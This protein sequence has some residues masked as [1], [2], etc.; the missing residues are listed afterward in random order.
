[1]S[2]HSPFCWALS[3]VTGASPRTKGLDSDRLA[4]VVLLIG[5]LA[6]C[7]ILGYGLIGRQSAG[8]PIRISLTVT[9][10]GSS[11]GTTLNAQTIPN[12]STL[13]NSQ[14]LQTVSNA[15]LAPDATSQALSLNL[16]AG[17][18]T[19]SLDS[20]ETLDLLLAN[21]NLWYQYQLYKAISI[22]PS[23]VCNLTTA[24]ADPSAATG[25]ILFQIP[26]SGI[27]YLAFI[28]D[29]YTNPTTAMY[30]VQISILATTAASSSSTG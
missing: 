14:N 15:L 21:A 30:S 12:Q 2:L 18:L 8:S 16:P 1:M 29:Y 22:C 9:T 27:Y 10:S 17:T 4:W 28:N 24:A 13:T 7:S 19:V 11:S 5:V 6:G 25:Q 23:N 20:N 3:R 26:A